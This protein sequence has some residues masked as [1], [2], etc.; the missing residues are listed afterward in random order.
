MKRAKKKMSTLGSFLA[1]YRPH[2]KMFILDLICALF[3]SLIDLSFP[4]FTRLAMQDLLPQRLYTPFF[5]IMGAL[6]L[7]YILRA[8]LMYIVTYFGHMLGVRMEAD[9]RKALFSHMQRLPFRFYDNHRTGQLMSR[10]TTDLFDI[11][12]LAHHGPEDLFISVITIAGA[13]I[14]MFGINLKLALL[15][16]V[17]LPLGVC[18]TA[19]QRKRMMSASK[20]VKARQ[21]GINA[22]L[23]SGISGARVAKAF[24]NE[25]YEIEKFEETNE[26]FR[27]SKLEYYKAMGV[28]MSGMEFIMTLFNIAVIT[29]GGYLIMRGA[30]D[31]IGLITFTLYVGAFIAPIRKLTTFMEMFTN[32]MA[33]FSRFREILNIKPEIEDGPG[34]TPIENVRGDIAFKNVS[35][36]YNDKKSLLRH[37]NLH[38]RAGETLALVGPSGGGKT[39]L[40]HLI[41]RF[42]EIDEG[43]IS[44]D[45]RNIPDITIESLRSNIGIVSQDVFLF[46][47]TIKENIRYGRLD[48][49]DE[50]IVRAAKQAEIHDMIMQ[51]EDGYNTMVGDRGVRIS[52]GQKQRVSIARIF[53]KNPPILIL[54]EATSALDSITE[55]KI[56]HAFEALCVGRTT[57]VIAH[58]LS[59][60]QKADEIIVLTETG[61]AE[62][63][64]HDAL[65]K[66]NGVYA[67][68]Y[69]SQF[70]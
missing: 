22:R 62:R 54:D 42:Y 11:T 37:I 51:M 70:A 38:I 59:T 43:E 49:T 61:I 5:L 23:E 4:L 28:F 44:I 19:A 39:T 60:V 67:S 36:S 35:F 24:V 31:Y 69:K 63:G 1:Y 20:E 12:E 7:S 52:G 58:R 40:C 68:L 9:M 66:Q 3:I 55:A 50:E 13:L 21:A 65:L 41:P 53:L 17:L 56:Q 8:F 34:A 48:A 25:H 64:T 29:L 26:F 27:H 18:F 2:W 46:A 14:I 15:L 33:G 57:L 32:G 30:F 16:M 6:L 47:D 45:G 10:V